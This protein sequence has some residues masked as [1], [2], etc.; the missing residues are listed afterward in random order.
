MT[1]ICAQQLCRSLGIFMS[2]IFFSSTNLWANG[3]WPN[4]LL[5]IAANGCHWRLDSNLYSFIVHFLFNSHRFLRLDFLHFLLLFA[6]FF[7][8][9]CC[10]SVSLHSFVY[11][12]PDASYVVYRFTY[13]KYKV[14]VRFD[15]TFF[16]CCSCF[17]ILCRQ[18][19]V[20]AMGK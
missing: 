13:V 3:R 18:V 2:R 6:F 1:V 8:F 7:S 12:A 4:K 10:C 16:F 11:F 14:S 15:E 17:W 5:T 19:L 9:C 20:S